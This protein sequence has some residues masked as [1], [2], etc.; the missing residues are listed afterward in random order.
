MKVVED[1]EIIRELEDGK[2]VETVIE[3]RRLEDES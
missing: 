1:V 3:T 2:I